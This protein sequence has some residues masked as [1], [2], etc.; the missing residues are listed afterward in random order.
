MTQNVS[1]SVREAARS[2]S[3]YSAR[4]NPTG[5][6]YEPGFHIQPSNGLI[7]FCAKDAGPHLFMKHD[8]LRLQCSLS[9]FTSGPT[10]TLLPNLSDRLSK[11]S[12]VEYE[13]ACIFL[14]SCTF[15][16][17]CENY[18]QLDPNDTNFAGV[19]PKRSIR[20]KRN[21][22]IAEEFPQSIYSSIYP[23]V[24]HTQVQRT[25]CLF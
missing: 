6:M 14:L 4:E 18:S 10:S 2:S 21:L 9:P 20:P 8:T 25:N 7:T 11:Y 19:G 22:L 13:S 16:P 24:S 23:G 5:S 1:E 17:G 15:H 12:L 3:G